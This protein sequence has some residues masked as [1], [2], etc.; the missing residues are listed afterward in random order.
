M[1]NKLIKE[2]RCIKW[3]SICLR[4]EL[5]TEERLLGMNDTLIRQIIRVDEERFPVIGKGFGINC[6]SMILGC[7][8]APSSTQVNSRL[9]HTTITIFKLVGRGSGSNGKKL[10]SE[11]QGFDRGR[12]GR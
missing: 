10:V 6:K 8:V 12:R 1:S 4:V 5:N 9:V 7:D 3:P 2:E 11:T